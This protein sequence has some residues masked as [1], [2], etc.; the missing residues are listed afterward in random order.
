MRLNF[1]RALLHLVEGIPFPDKADVTGIEFGLHNLREFCDASYVSREEMLQ[2]QTLPLRRLERL[3]KRREKLVPSQI[4]ISYRRIH[5]AR[6]SQRCPSIVGEKYCS[7]PSRWN[8]MPIAETPKGFNQSLKLSRLFFGVNLVL[9]ENGEVFL[10]INR[11]VNSLGFFEQDVII[12][13]RKAGKMDEFKQG[14]QEKRALLMLPIGTKEPRKQSRMTEFTHTQAE[15]LQDIQVRRGSSPIR[16]RYAIRLAK[17]ADEV[18]EVGSSLRRRHQER[19]R[20]TRKQA[21]EVSNR[22]VSRTIIRSVVIYQHTSPRSQSQLR[23]LG[24]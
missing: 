15:R 20:E 19:L 1:F 7:P 3:V 11:N 23:L 5:F 9:D 18:L 17:L 16:S 21:L 6:T 22:H 2:Q 24:N 12:L 4:Y 14:V 10:R 13:T 8:M